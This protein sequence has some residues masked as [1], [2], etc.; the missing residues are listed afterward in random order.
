MQTSFKIPVH[1]LSPAFIKD[2]QDKYGDAELE[3]T[4]NRQPDFQ[5]LS[6]TEFW[7]LMELLDWKKETNVA[8]TEPLIK[9]LSSLHVA[10]IYNFQEIL[11]KKLYHLDQKKYAR[12]IGQYAYKK[13]EYFSVDHFLHV[14]ACVVANGKEAYQEVVNTPKTMFKDLTF[15]PLLS[16]ASSA[17]ER[18]TQKRFSY[19]PSLSYETYSN[20]K[21]WNIKSSQ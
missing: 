9:K 3:I 11:S 8:I 15:E 6:E 4:V 10:H 18:K 21:G 14:R 1:K 5:P 16:V 13:G 2:M 20:K 7:Q 19:I 12:H 17:Y